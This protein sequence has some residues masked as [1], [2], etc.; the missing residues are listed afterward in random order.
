MG[1]QKFKRPLMRT[2]DVVAQVERRT[3]TG[4]LNAFGLSVIDG[5]GSTTDKTMVLPLP[6]YAG[7]QKQIVLN[8]TGAQKVTVTVGGATAAGFFVG[9]G[10]NAAGSTYRS[11]VFS[12][13]STQN[14][15]V[16]L[17]GVS[18]AAW[19]IVAKSTGVTLA[20]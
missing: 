9:G 2:G 16:S 8:T 10:G 3:S 17:V 20:G 6:T 1:V 11:L 5:T 4:T 19:A 7:Q 18:A 13:K 12:S 15:M 14:R